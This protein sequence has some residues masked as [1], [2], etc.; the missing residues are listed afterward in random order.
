[1]KILNC[2]FLLL[3]AASATAFAQPADYSIVSRDLHSRTWARQVA[4]TNALGRVITRTNC[5]QELA[6]GMH[7]R[8]TNG[9]LLESRE[10]FVVLPDHSA[11]VAWRGQ[12][13][14][15]APAS[16]YDSAVAITLP[17]GEILRTRPIAISY[18]DGTN[19]VLIAEITN[20]AAQLS[21]DHCKVI[22]PSCF[23]DIDADIVLVNHRHGA[24]CDLVIHSPPEAPSAFGLSDDSPTL[25]L[26]LLS[27]VFD[28]PEPTLESQ[29]PAVTNLA[30]H[31]PA[32]Q[33]ADGVRDAAGLR[34]PS[35]RMP[36]GRAFFI[37]A[38]GASP[39]S[40]KV[41]KS[42]VH[43]QNRVF[44]LEEIPYSLIA[45]ELQNLHASAPPVEDSKVLASA[46][47]A[48]S[49]RSP[50][51]VDRV[52]PSSQWSPP[53]H[54]PITRSPETLELAKT[55]LPARSGFVLDYELNGTVTNFTLTG[56]SLVT[57]P[58]YV[59]GVLTISPNSVTK[60]TN[61]PLAKISFSG[62][63]ASRADFYGD[64]IFTCQNDNSIGSAAP[65]STGSPT[66]TLATCLE[67]TSDADNTYKHLRFDFAGT[68]VSITR[69]F[70]GN[71][72]WHCQF[73][74]CGSAVSSAA[75]RVNVYNSL[76]SKC[77]TAL[78][79]WGF[80][81]AQNAT[82]DQC[83]TLG[84]GFDESAS[85]VNCILAAVT[86]I[87]ASFT[88]VSCLQ[89]ASGSGIFTPVGGGSYYLN[90]ALENT[91]STN[92]HPGLAGDLRQ[93]TTQ[94]PI[95]ISNT[96][97]SGDLNLAP[98]AQRDTDVPDEG[99]HYAPLDFAVSAIRMT[100]ALNIT[101]APG[102]V[103]AAF[104]G[105]WGGWGFNI[106]HG[107]RMSAAGSATLPCRLV[108]YNCVQEQPA[109]AWS[110]PI[111]FGLVTDSDGDTAAGALDFRFTQWSSPAADVFLLYVTT[112]P[113]S[114]SH[115]KFSGGTVVGVVSPVN[116]T[117]CLL[118]NVTTEIDPG[119]PAG[120]R[121][122]T[123][124]GGTLYSFTWGGITNY[125]I[126]DNI[127]DH[128][129]LINDLATYGYDGGHNAFV[130][131]CDRLYPT[132]ACDILLA[133]SPAYQIGPLG[134]Y[135]LPQLGPLIN[136]G[137]WSGTNGLFH[138]STALDQRKE[139]NSI[140]D[141]GFHA[142][143]LAPAAPPTIWCDDSVP[144]GSTLWMN[145]DRWTWINDPMPFSGSFCHV[146]D[147]YATWHQHVFY[148][149]SAT[150][151]PGPD[152]TLFC[153]IYLNPTNLPSE[154]MLQFEAIDGSWWYH[155]ALWGADVIQGWGARTYMG[156]LP[157]AGGWVRFEV[158]ARALGLV[159]V[160]IDGI[161]FT[162]GSGSAAW[163]YAG[164]IGVRTPVDSDRDGI[165]DYLENTTGT[166]RYESDADLCNWQV[167][168]TDGDGMNDGYE[169]EISRTDPKIPNGPIIVSQPRSQ[170][171]SKADTV[172]LS[173]EAMGAQP[174]RY[175]W[176][177][178]GTVP[179]EGETNSVLTLD[180]V[181]EWESG[182]FS[183]CVTSSTGLSSNSS[184]ASVTIID[185]GNS[186]PFVVLLGP[187]WDYTFQSG[188]TYYVGSEIELFGTTRIQGNSIIKFDPT[189]T[190]SSL[191]INGSL[192]SEAKPYYPATLTSQDDC[193]VGE[194]ISTSVHAPLSGT[195][196]SAYLN[197]ADATNCSLANLRIRFADIGIL[198]PKQ[199]LDVWDTQFLQ[200]RAALSGT[201]GSSPFLH[202]VLLGS[203]GT[204]ITCAVSVAEV[205]CEHVTADTVTFWAGPVAPAKIHLTN[206]ILQGILTAG[207][208]LTTDCVAMNPSGQVF[209]TNSNG[210]YYL[211][212]DS[213]L[214]GSGTTNISA[215]LIS[216]L[217]E[218]TTE[219]AMMLPA[220]MRVTEDL[221]LREVAGR[222]TSGRPDLGWHYDPLDVTVAK[223]VL[224]GGAVTVLP[225]TVVGVRNEALQDGTWTTE[226][227]LL[228]RGASFTSQGTPTRPNT[229]TIAQ[230]VQENPS[231]FWEYEATLPIL[232]DAITFVTAY[233]PDD[234]DGCAP[235][236]N[237]RFSNFYLP[238][239]DYHIW[240]GAC[241]FANVFPSL[242]SSAYCSLTDCLVTGGRINFGNPR[243]YEVIF[244][245]GTISW[246]NNTFDNVSINLDPSYY[247]YNQLTNCDMYVELL[248]NT[249][250]KCPWLIVGPFPN[251][252]GTWKFEDNLFDRVDFLQ[253][254]AEDLLHDHNGYYPLKPWA[255]KWS[256][257][258]QQQGLEETGLLLPR[259]EISH[260]VGDV[261]LDQAPPF[262][263]G[264]FGDHYMMPKTALDFAGGFEVCEAG[265]FHYTTWTNQT[266][267]GA[268]GAEHKI[269][270]GRHY[271][272]T[273]NGIPI[274]TDG[275]GIADYVENASGTGVASASETDWQKKYTSEGVYDTTNAVYDNADLSG[276]GLVGRM[277]KALKLDPLK[278]NNPFQ[279]TQVLSGLEP[280]IVAFQVPIPYPLSYTGLTA[281]ASLDLQVDG[282]RA[283]VFGVTNSG[284][285]CL[286]KWNT[287]FEAPGPH[288]VG[289][290]LKLKG[291]R[292]Q[293]SLQPEVV[294]A[295]GP[296]CISPV[297]NSLGFDSY[298]SSYYSDTY[299]CADLSVET[300]PYV[301]ALYNPLSNPNIPFRTMSGSA[302]QYRI[303]EFWDGKD[304]GG[305]S[306]P[307]DSVRVQVTV[308]LDG[309]PPET[310]SELI[311]RRST[312]CIVPD[313]LFTVAYTS[314]FGS[315]DYDAGNNYFQQM[316]VDVLLNPANQSFQGPP[317]SSS[318]NVQSYGGLGGYAGYLPD[319]NT[320]DHLIQ[321]SLAP[322]ASSG[323]LDTRNF[324]FYGHGN[325]DWLGNYENTVSFTSGDVMAA[326][327]NDYDPA[328]NAKKRNHPYRLVF[329]EACYTAEDSTWAEAFGIE[330][331]HF[332]WDYLQRPDGVQALVGWR[333]ECKMPGNDDQYAA[334]ANTLF[335]I[336]GNWMDQ[337]PIYYVI[338]QAERAEPENWGNFL[339]FPLK[340]KLK[341]DRPVIRG[342]GGIL[343]TGLTTNF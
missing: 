148:G 155:R 74:N 288:I 206:S 138:F 210:R 334:F 85:L 14:V 55:D 328:T 184:S 126:K 113:A 90:A 9:A 196:G 118:E 25:R 72:F 222:Y 324:F 177:W 295:A 165:P 327:Q 142:V 262:Q 301:I 152:D 82:F 212:K 248:S 77:G 194:W 223:V 88:L 59:S 193:S 98:Q 252:G 211:C 269:S 263:A 143:A 3:L 276:D 26:Q 64:A 49:L 292:P 135:Y 182:S 30:V 231:G 284:G 261:V 226:G 6:S 190:N 312:E 162:L 294:A 109:S 11:A 141:L 178:N 195:N 240:G 136:G 185:C 60:F 316:V 145:N 191:R 116:L 129:A 96:I 119:V 218:K 128:T 132:N 258:A 239:Q 283:K 267:E 42:W 305:V 323:N 216:E 4:I 43:Y 199:T 286:I 107:A 58:F 47:R 53:P 285:N 175:Q 121:N 68:A 280:D 242:D 277:K 338:A 268:T 234:G 104:K 21:P 33:S 330:E 149:T 282:A 13:K 41:R 213:A 18:A 297:R 303:T 266:K 245:P 51:L 220:L 215:R 147:T 102:T 12:H 202:N 320:V 48:T 57:G 310:H 139:T 92:I 46:G 140:V 99:F 337:K 37:G 322:V 84:N 79:G 38:Q 78:S 241:E 34:F 332:P 19:N 333:G 221:V 158:P 214:R 278:L 16:L 256:V 255:Y 95:V 335:F 10:D 63:L 209:Q 232:C 315:F 281:V 192:V 230:A 89:A 302:T 314:D 227:F 200:C 317:Y 69:G 238:L 171:V 291:P 275:D 94:P 22:W 169:V 219:P 339:T 265:L 103:V 91:G 224:A 243:Y 97:L 112:L 115:S 247:W 168:D 326:L 127:F 173:V 120:I 187:R 250:I 159:G 130:A 70:T 228:Q 71:E 62:P 134:N 336:F 299:I 273:T 124:V 151:T 290:R 137:T 15:Y 253:D 207:P 29:A 318:F 304:D 153:Y 313:G 73:L 52:V 264:P 217:R 161:G 257:W 208:S 122:C 146:S 87:D 236:M 246:K 8:G 44:L 180:N 105:T 204:L 201:E 50:S 27:E 75:E 307:G 186:W 164:V 233:D 260:G 23:T 289:A 81:T 189:M 176:I 321:D 40:F 154:V 114:V 251:S 166:G 272:A 254:T 183:V 167:P 111:D 331:E 7:Y 39:K 306:Y 123:F 76:F 325:T 117:N 93:L 66:R 244:T 83:G 342:Y 198:L 106:D 20:S 150:L 100:N 296:I 181:Q 203:C 179:I 308:N 197:L 172:T 235:L 28:S 35:M 17:T 329:L 80:F 300:A 205:N 271:I 309:A 160:S 270:I 67:D 65:Y 249:F 108:S 237:F 343:R 110:E 36:A 32:D 225:G 45:S 61:S 24:E 144:A 319:C 163:D 293:V 86:N 174:L 5:I 156:A 170:T 2:T 125:V 311:N 188:F 56:D 31:L 287:T 1:M 157:P 340:G 279:L 274:D 131:G 101:L 54:R 298:F 229:F 259:D 133:A 341:T